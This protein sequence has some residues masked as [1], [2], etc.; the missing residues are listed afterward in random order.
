MWQHRPLAG[1]LVHCGSS[2][3]FEGVVMMRGVLL[4][5]AA[6]V[7]ALLAGCTSPGPAAA[8]PW[9]APVTPS[10]S[11]RTA[12]CAQVRS[13]FGDAM[14]PLGTALGQ[15]VGAQAAGDRKAANAAGQDAVSELKAISAK[16]TTISAGAA[17]ADLRQAIT[18]A[19]GS[20]DQLA[21]DPTFLSDVGGI[22]DIPSAVGKVSTAANQ[23]ASACA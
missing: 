5:A 11:A 18:S 4:V 12:V 7:A 10:G 17:D 8:A 20:I 13:A 6:G 14:E 15:L 22:T 1:P 16:L 19:K 23:V 21:A 2:Y 3:R 9:S